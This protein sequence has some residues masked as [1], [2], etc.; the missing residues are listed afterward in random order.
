MITA[1]INGGA[2]L[3]MLYSSLIAGV[4]VAVVFSLAVLGA[5]RAGDMRRE[6]RAAASIAFGALAVLAVLASAG[7][8]VYG[9]ILLTSK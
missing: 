3:K 1:S 2:L 5:T 9:L 8:V 4:S 6:R 7:I